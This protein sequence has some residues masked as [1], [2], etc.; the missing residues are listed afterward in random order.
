MTISDGFG[1]PIME[2]GEVRVGTKRAFNDIVDTIRTLFQT[3]VISK[4]ADKDDNVITTLIDIDIDE[5]CKFIKK[6]GR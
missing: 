3:N 2:H 6:T 1:K 4:V 5:F